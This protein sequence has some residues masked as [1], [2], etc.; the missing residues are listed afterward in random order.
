MV[1]PSPIYK[2]KISTIFDRLS[3]QK[4]TFYLFP[5]DTAIGEKFHTI[6]FNKKSIS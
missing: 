6:F 4:P 5:R 1:A 3:F 2:L